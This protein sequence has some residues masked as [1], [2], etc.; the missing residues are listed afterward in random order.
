[1]VMKAASTGYP[2]SI[3]IPNK[4]VINNIVERLESRKKHLCLWHN[5]GI[6]GFKGDVGV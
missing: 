5:N 3:V 4:K 6:S 1:M 2:W